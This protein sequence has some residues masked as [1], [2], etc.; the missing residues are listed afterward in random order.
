M[1]KAIREGQATA[2]LPRK[3]KINPS[4][5]TQ[6]KSLSESND[7]GK[8]HYPVHGI[9]YM[10][11]RDSSLSRSRTSS[12]GSSD[13]GNVFRSRSQSSSDQYEPL[14]SPRA[15]KEFERLHSEMTYAEPGS[16]SMKDK[17][18]QLKEQIQDA[19]EQEKDAKEGKELAAQRY[20][21]S[22]I[23]AKE[24]KWR[25]Q[26][27]E[28]KLQRV[29]TK[30]EN[31]RGRLHERSRI[32]QESLGNKKRAEN[33]TKETIREKENIEYEIT[34]VNAARDSALSRL[35][36]VSRR[37]AIK[38]AAVQNAQDHFNA[39]S[40][41]SKMLSDMKEMYKLRINNIHSR[42]SQLSM[43]NEK[44]VHRIHILE[45]SIADCT[46]RFKRAEKMILPL[47]I[48][49]NQLQDALTEEKSNTRRLSYELAAYQQRLRAARHYTDF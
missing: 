43:K 8:V 37:L 39:M 11:R 6:K 36:E 14:V 21:K 28:D 17:V 20:K 16:G 10:T 35:R 40:A 31:T 34:E 12:T 19:I 13:S 4:L 30:L 46:E 9:D 41:R 32:V 44:Q 29:E 47:K 49:I 23:L 48:Y 25:M 33:V 2:K 24:L 3:P 45:D 15:V 22:K 27:V 26:D 18:K 1:L 38:Q 42:S 5:V 7:Y